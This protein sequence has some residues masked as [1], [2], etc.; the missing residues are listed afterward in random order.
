[1]TSFLKPVIS[2]KSFSFTKNN[3]ISQ[4]SVESTDIFWQKFRESNFL[5]KKF[6]NR[7]FDKIFVQF[8]SKQLFTHVHTALWKL[9]KFTLPEKNSSNQLFSDFCCKS[10]T[11]TKVLPKFPHC[12]LVTCLVRPFILRNFCQRFRENHGFT[13]KLLMS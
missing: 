10:G 9:Q 5:I 4:L 1:M 12:A 11:F 3:F 8:L 2:P 7:W 6:L 13:K